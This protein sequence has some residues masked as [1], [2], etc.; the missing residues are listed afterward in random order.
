MR[1]DTTF[2]GS[3]DDLDSSSYPDVQLESPIV[4][5]L[6]GGHQGNIYS[7]NNLNKDSN[8]DP[9]WILKSN[10]NDSKI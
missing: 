5:D 8:K 10:E 6:D 7:N 2:I 4:S 1:E 9:K 3:N